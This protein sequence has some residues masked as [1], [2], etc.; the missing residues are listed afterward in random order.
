MESSNNLQA[1]S[2][3]DAAFL[4]LER[5]TAE[6]DQLSDRLQTSRERIGDI[7]G[8]ISQIKTDADS[9]ERAKR[10][11]RLT[12]LNSA[13]EL[14]QADDSA[15]VAKIVTAKSKVLQAGRAVRNLISQVLFQ[16]SQKRKLN[17]VHLLETEFVTRKIPVRIADIANNARG[18][19]ELREVEELLT[20]PLRGRDE[21][22]GA[23]YTL[24]AKFEPVRAGV[25]AEENLALEIRTA[26]GQE[27]A[28]AEPVAESQLVEA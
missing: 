5:K 10:I 8:E 12:S 15:I 13:R 18:V 6:L 28:V 17:A 19:V 21:E 20:R 27:P 11:S 22:L 14:A 1:L 9:L 26:A 16:L 24:K 7:D 3:V 23:L 4:D 2:I 25:L